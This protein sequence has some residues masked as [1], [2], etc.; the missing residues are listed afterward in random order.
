MINFFILN[1]HFRLKLILI[2]CSDSALAFLLTSKYTQVYTSFFKYINSFH[3]VKHSSP[4]NFTGFRK[5]KKNLITKLTSLKKYPC[6][7]FFKVIFWVHLFLK[8][9]YFSTKKVVV[10]HFKL[11]INRTQFRTRF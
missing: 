2:L 3:K 10:L 7:S 11:I 5:I 8:H 9:L 4:T 1:F 6:G